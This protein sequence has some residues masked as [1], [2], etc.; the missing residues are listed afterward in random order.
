MFEFSFSVVISPLFISLVLKIT[1]FKS[2]QLK[3]ISI[4]P[5]ISIPVVDFHVAFLTAL[6]YTVEFQWTLYAVPFHAANAW[7]LQPNSYTTE[8]SLCWWSAYFH[9]TIII[10]TWISI[11]HWN[12]YQQ[13]DEIYKSEWWNEAIH[14]IHYDECRRWRM[15][16]TNLLRNEFFLSPWFCSSYDVHVKCVFTFNKSTG[17]IGWRHKTFSEVWILSEITSAQLTCSEH[18]ALRYT[19]MIDK[20]RPPN[21]ASRKR[22]GN[23]V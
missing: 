6:Q 19:C 22:T 17:I 15:T 7:T 12:K 20:S 14:T 13:R 8:L 23:I 9:S 5:Y 11:E 4:F 3:L 16:S 21:S 1:G 18:V 2:K 10:T